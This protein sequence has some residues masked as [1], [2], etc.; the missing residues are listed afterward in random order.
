MPRRKRDALPQLNGALQKLVRSN[1]KCPPQKARLASVNY[2]CGD[3]E[4]K[5]MRHKTA[6]PTPQRICIIGC[7][8]LLFAPLF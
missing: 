8:E 4:I 5:A 1:G 6:Q 2:F 7:D 3:N